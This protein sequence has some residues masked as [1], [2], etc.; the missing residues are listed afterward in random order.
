MIRTGG[1]ARTGIGSSLKHALK[2]W[3]Q[4]DAVTWIYLF[5]AL[6]ASCLT[7]W[8]SMR[9]ELPQ[10][11]T[12]I[13]TVF[14]VM[15][16]LSGHVLAKSIYR[17]I[18]TL[19]GSAFSVLL[20]AVFPQNN[21]L[22]LGGLAL[23]VFV[24]STGAARQRNF[25]AYGFVLAGYTAVMI[26]LPV[27]D[28][29]NRVFMA[30]VWRV[31]EI[32]LGIGCAS[33]IS[34]TVF[35]LTTSSALL[36]SVNVRFGSFADF[37][38]TGLRKTGK[39]DEFERV[40]LRF[41]SEAVGLEVLR[42]ITTFEDPEMRRRSGRLNRLNSEFM[43][44]T[45]R[46]NALHQLLERRGDV[47]AGAHASGTNAEW[48]ALAAL[49]EP[50][51]GRSL[52]EDDANRL[53][54][55]LETFKE[56]LPAAIRI[57]RSIFERGKPSRDELLDFNTAYELLY[58]FVEELREYA[59][60]HASLA[61]HSHAREDWSEPFVAQTNW[62]ASIAAGLRSACVLLV[63]SWLWIVTT[64]PSGAAMTLVS[65]LTVGLSAFSTNPKRMSFQIACGTAAT[66]AI[67]VF[68][69]FFVYPLIDG[70]P[71]LCLVIAPVIM[72][73]TY[74]L[75][76]PQW[77]GYGLGMLVFFGTNSVPANLT[78]YNPYGLINDYLAMVFGMLV[79]AVAGA[80]ILPPNSPWLWRRL[81]RDLRRQVVFAIRAPL[82][83]LASGFDS[84][85]RDL[86][87]QANGFAT[88]H[89]DVQRSLLRWT[90]VVLDVGHAIIELRR[91]EAK[92]P[93]FP[94]YR[95]SEPWRQSLRLMSRALMRLFVK[96]GAGNLRRCLAAVE[97]SI[98]CVQETTEPFASHFQT[99]PLRR[100]ESYLH[101]IRTS[102]L[103]PNTPL[104]IHLP[105][106]PSQ[107]DHYVS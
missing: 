15:Q 5:K 72:L 78:I 65:A 50:Y 98:N 31:L 42:S 107:G 94:C 24:C 70:F 20:M 19:A 6:I 86:M 53:A 59:L 33:L 43:A 88:G 84:G 80:V 11:A 12:A 75:A 74:L 46:F 1:A 87:H 96:P 73:G 22:F 10:P 47:G 62:W 2:D 101:F 102:L 13:T 37:A 95:E 93:D 58:R 79:C 76:R 55:Q 56:R 97:R 83:A 34:A 48:V 28:H 7:L 99:S 66:A 103:A 45:T 64:W 14:I 49:I 61:D 39:N 27:V 67:G 4:T 21:E 68:E 23:W 51:A 3:A 41:F 104:S 17:F 85:T 26:A 57:K 30:A 63:L 25:R 92:L 82:Q 90:L 35:P 54:A 91:E 71:L 18:G 16:P 8:L 89:P 9:F 38:V 29:P 100:V 105:A 36:K 81:E 44:V 40:N 52:L 77:A 106:H 69:V 60:T 32:S